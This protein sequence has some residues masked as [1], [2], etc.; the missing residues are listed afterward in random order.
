MS[1]K[2]FA[3]LFALTISRYISLL[4]DS[5]QILDKSFSLSCLFARQYQATEMPGAKKA[6]CYWS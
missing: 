3:Y 1:H 2:F 5:P 4:E 6:V